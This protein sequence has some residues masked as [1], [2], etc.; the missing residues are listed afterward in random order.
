MKKWVERHWFDFDTDEELSRLRRFIEHV[1]PEFPAVSKL[2]ET[3]ILQSVRS[4][5]TAH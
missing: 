1:R 2:L 3:A 4:L 5:H